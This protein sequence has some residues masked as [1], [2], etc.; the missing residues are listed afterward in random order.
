MAQDVR[1]PHAYMWVTTQYAA[2]LVKY[3]DTTQ[4]FQDKTYSTIGIAKYANRTQDTVHYFYTYVR[5]YCTAYV[6]TYMYVPYHCIHSAN[7]LGILM[8]YASPL[9]RRP[10]FRGA[11][12]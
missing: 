12:Y 1:S 6:S 11:L 10:L 2:N 9:G 7:T 4:N 3:R 5:A 8:K